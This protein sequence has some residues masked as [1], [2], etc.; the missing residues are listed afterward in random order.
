MPLSELWLL[1]EQMNP[2]P[3]WSTLYDSECSSIF[4]YGHLETPILLKETPGA[5]DS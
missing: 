2:A 1:L 4:S 5:H 3:H